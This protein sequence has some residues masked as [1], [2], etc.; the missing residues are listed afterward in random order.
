MNTPHLVTR[1]RTTSATPR[2]EA[3]DCG[4][5]GRPDGTVWVAAG[6]SACEFTGSGLAGSDVSA[7]HS[8]TPPI[9]TSAMASATAAAAM[10]MRA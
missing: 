7:P 1:Q 10:K 6:G 2:V 3:E 5:L 4:C 8:A 9:T